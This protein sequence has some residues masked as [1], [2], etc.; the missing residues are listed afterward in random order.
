[1]ALPPDTQLVETLG[2]GSFGV[3][4][5]ARLRQ[6]AMH[7]TVVLKVLKAAWAEDEE[8]LSC[9]PASSTTTSSASRS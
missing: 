2:E 1:M 7:R 8:V 6:G 9:S 5:V 3:V 4:Y